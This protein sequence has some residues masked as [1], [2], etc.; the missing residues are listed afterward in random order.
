MIK[1]NKKMDKIMTVRK[2]P[3]LKV[4]T[5]AQVDPKKKAKMRK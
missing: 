1:I 3:L 2:C 4:A 5:K